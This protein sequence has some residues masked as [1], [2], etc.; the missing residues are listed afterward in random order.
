MT[1]I[2]MQ[3]NS[4]GKSKV[5][6][7]GKLNNIN[8]NF[9]GKE[10]THQENF[11]VIKDLSNPI[12]LSK[13]FL[14]RTGAIHNHREE[15]IDIDG[16]LIRM[17]GPQKSQ[18]NSISKIYA[19]KKILIPPRTAKY[20]PINVPNLNKIDVFIEPKD[21]AGKVLISRGVASVDKDST[22]FAI[23]F[24]P[25]PKVQFI[26]KLDEL[27]TATVI[28]SKLDEG[29]IGYAVL[30]EKRGKTGFIKITHQN[31]LNGLEKN[32]G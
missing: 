30:T 12:N 27:G 31:I 18:I 16:E 23:A 10:K 7:V 8:F 9:E 15:T 28:S 29:D 2:K 13:Q 25:C 14:S 4:A 5:E 3:V 32:S 1:P 11:L 20:I 21:T 26:E 17:E 19:Q 24:N 6:I 22:S